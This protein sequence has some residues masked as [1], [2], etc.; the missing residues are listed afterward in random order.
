MSQT[1]KP[2][3]VY[4]GEHIESSHVVH[5]AVVTAKGGLLAYYGNPFRLTFARSSMKPFQAIPAVES[6]ALETYGISKKELALFCASHSGE[7]YHRK[8]VADV[9]NKIN[10]QESDLQCGTH[11]PR[12]TESYKE[13]IKSG[14]ELTPFYSN[15]SGKHS[16]MLTGC[17]MQNMDTASYREISHPYQQQILHV[18]ADVAQYDRDK[19][20]ISV[21]G[22]GVPVHRVPLYNLALAFARLSK[23]QN[24][25][26]GSDKRKS[27]LDQIRDAMMTHPEM[28]A[29]T[30][31]FDTDLMA[32]FDQRI[33]AKGGAEGVH[34]F[35]VRETGIGVAL[36]VVDGNGRATSVASMEILKQLTIGEKT[37]WDKLEPYVHAPVLNARNETIGEIKPD[38]VL[39]YV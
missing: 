8:S 12:D 34:C 22:C 5:I 27:S 26:G 30:N 37:L 25:E 39:N 2:I 21:D 38:F 9:L 16:G 36:K 32:A 23:P 11:V 28:V 13:L 3:K 19:I 6:N 31:R 14:G 20:A 1:T 24:W 10:L 18:I 17:V 7:P 33:V 35:G 15:C 4:R 29:G